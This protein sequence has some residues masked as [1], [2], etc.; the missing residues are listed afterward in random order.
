MCDILMRCDD[1][2]TEG[3]SP[4]WLPGWDLPLHTTRDTA[5]TSAITPDKPTIADITTLIDV[6]YGQVSRTTDEGASGPEVFTLR[7]RLLTMHFD[8]VDT[9]E[10]YTYLHTLE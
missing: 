7:L 2:C 6:C 5:I 8:R 4:S 10:G 3:R 1:R 9:G